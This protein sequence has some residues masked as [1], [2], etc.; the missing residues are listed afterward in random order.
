MAR[1]VRLPSEKKIK[2]VK[3]YLAGKISVAKII[4]KHGILKQTFQ[5]W[6]RLYQTR[7]EEGLVPS[8]TNRKYPTEIKIKAVQDYQAGAGSLCDICV[9]YDISNH[10]MVQKWIMMYNSHKEFEQPKS[11]GANYM[12]KGRETVQEERIEIVIHCISNNKNYIK[13]STKSG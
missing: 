6:V 11:G 5:G 1:K 13:T 9:K 10:S 12:A 8:A 2:I 7:G 3:K 4:Q